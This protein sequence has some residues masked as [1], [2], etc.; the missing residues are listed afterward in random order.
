MTSEGYPAFTYI[1]GFQD[2]DLWFGHEGRF[3]GV[4]GELRIYP[5]AGYVVIVMG[6]LDPP[7][8]TNLAEFIGARLPA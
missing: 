6:N 5:H 7:V 2:G 8:A 4:N 1:L 3:E